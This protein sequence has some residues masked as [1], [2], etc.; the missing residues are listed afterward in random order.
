MAAAGEEVKLVGGWASPFVLRVRI[1]LHLKGAGYEYLQE[2]HGKKSE[3]LLKSNPVY[4]KIPVLIHN[5]KPICESMHIVEYV[6][7]VWASRLKPHAGLTPA[8]PYKRAISRFWAAY[9]DDKLP[10]AVRI[11][12][13]ALEGSKEQA[14]EQI[15]TTV[16]LLEDAFTKCCKGKKFF[17]GETIGYI[18][19]AFGSWL[20]W[21]K[22]VE[23]MFGIKFFDGEKLPLLF[24]WAERFWSNDAVVVI[25]PQV[26]MLIEYSKAFE[27][28]N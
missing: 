26:D 17:G 12:I 4:K 18:D 2:Q 7:E 23:K 19:I 27:K 28:K 13:G 8:D 10:S 20:G 25:M 11:L 16:Q 9:I 6:D 15:F 22:A 21:L 3:L 24:G 14:I 1:A 5:G